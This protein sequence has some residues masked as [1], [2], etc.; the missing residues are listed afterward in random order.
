MNAPTTTGAGMDI[1]IWLIGAALTVYGILLAGLFV[2][3]VLTE[4]AGPND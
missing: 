1:I 3:A 2:V 4:I